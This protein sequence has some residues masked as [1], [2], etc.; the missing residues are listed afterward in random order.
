MKTKRHKTPAGYVAPLKSRAAIV[1]WLLD[2][3]KSNSRPGYGLFTYNVKLHR[4]KTDFAHLCKLAR[5]SGELAADASP[6]YLAAVEAVY[7]E[8]SRAV[9]ESAEE[10]ARDQLTGDDTNR[11]LWNGDEVLAEW[12]FDGRSGGW[13][14]LKS[15]GGVTLGAF[16]A[17]E[18]L[19]TPEQ[20]GGPSYKWLRNLYRFL[21]QCDHDFRRPESEVEYQAAFTLFA[22]FAADVETDQQAAEREAGEAKEAAEVAHWAARDTVT[23]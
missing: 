23:V 3:A 10:T 2:R 14:V 20:D 8:H 22:N 4:L 13:L 19:A 1:A 11:V 17:E 5:E 9:W 12:A 21:V 18:L 6:R 16:D 15:F 7:D